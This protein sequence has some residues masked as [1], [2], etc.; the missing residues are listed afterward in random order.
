[1]PQ[2]G[3]KSRRPILRRM[4]SLQPPIPPIGQTRQ[5]GRFLRNAWYVAA[6]PAILAEGPGQDLPRRSGR[7]VPRQAGIAQPLRRPLP[8]L[9]RAT[10]H[11]RWSAVIA[12]PLSRAALRRHRRLAS[13]TRTRRDRAAGLGTGLSAGRALPAAVDLDGRTARADDTLIPISPGSPS[14][15]G[16]RSRHRSCGRPYSWQRQH[17]RPRPRQFR[18]PGAGRQQLDDRQ[19]PV[20]P[21]RG[22][23]ALYTHADDFLSEGISAI[24]STQG[25]KQGP[26]GRRYAGTRRRPTSCDFRAGDPGTP[27][28]A[29]HRL[30]VA[31]R[32]HR[33]PPTPLIISG[34][35]RAFRGRRRELQHDR[36]A[37]HSPTPSSMR[38]CRSSRLP[39]ADGR[40]DFWT[41]ARCHSPATAAA[42]AR[43]PCAQAADRREQAGDRMAAV[44]G[45]PAHFTV[46][47]F[48]VDHGVGRRMDRA[49]QRGARA[50]AM[51][52]A[53]DLL[54]RIITYCRQSRMAETTFGRRA[55]ATASWSPGC[56]TAAASRSTPP[57]G[58]KPSSPAIRRGKAERHE[59]RR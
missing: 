43:S 36:R 48:V 38:T 27:V 20:P 7:P 39:P 13:S 16:T 59:R 46:G 50:M 6:G 29:L 5:R 51:L 33:R 14:R 40:R 45:R 32:L 17:P 49:R 54:D 19:A 44:V 53:A 42:C 25:R 21:G 52:A 12:M 15:A 30:A 8:T 41:P 23:G 11:A 10:R 24:L 2:R 28:D 9:R 34:R 18:P 1:M 47:N 58:S 56:A 4:T 22:S 31:S 57:P 26:L 55:S 35:R 3:R 37:T